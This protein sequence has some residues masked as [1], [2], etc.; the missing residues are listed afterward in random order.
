MPTSTV[1]LIS[2]ASNLTP[3]NQAARSIKSPKS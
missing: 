1:Q 3:D 2:L